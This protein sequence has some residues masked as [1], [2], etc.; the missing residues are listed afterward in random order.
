[1]V[2]CSLSKHKSYEVQNIIFNSV[3]KSYQLTLTNKPSGCS[4][5]IFTSKKLELKVVSDNQAPFLH[6]NKRDGVPELVLNNMALVKNTQTSRT[7]A[8]SQAQAPAPMQ[9]QGSHFSFLYVILGVVVAVLLFR[10]LFKKRNQQQAYYPN[11]NNPNNLPGGMNPNNP[12][13][14]N[15]P[16]NPQNGGFAQQQGPSRAGTF[17]S[18]LAGG[19]L[20]AVVGNS[21][22]DK[23]KGNEAQASQ[24]PTPMNND[25]TFSSDSGS[26][27]DDD[28]F[29]GSDDSFSSD[30]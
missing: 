10:F 2:N 26:S 4:E 16:N 5:G 13:G 1:M 28:S 6:F 15:Y 29:G 14:N 21:L 8:S 30:D 24:N 25:D 18:G 19:V 23:F 11:N 17:M 7:E 12:Q 3:D 22:Y 9:A 20:G 27:Y